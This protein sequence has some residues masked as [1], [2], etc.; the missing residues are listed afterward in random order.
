MMPKLH[1]TEHEG[2]E[3]IRPFYFV[4]EDDIINWRDK[5]GLEFL[6]CACKITEKNEALGIEEVGS[7]REEMKR[8]IKKL[9]KNYDKIDMNIYNATKR[10]NLDTIIS[11]TKNGK[12]YNFL[13]E[14]DSF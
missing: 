10:V 13:D 12:E 4:R 14:Y 1:S 11:Y 5:N 8:L 9:K 3:L 7:K 2:M 6:R